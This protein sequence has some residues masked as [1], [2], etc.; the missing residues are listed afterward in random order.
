MAIEDDVYPW[1]FKHLENMGWN[2]ADT[3]QVARKV[4]VNGKEADLYE[5]TFQA[6]MQKA[7]RGELVA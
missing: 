1:V 2:T 7:F 3:S 6:L 4:K 5:R